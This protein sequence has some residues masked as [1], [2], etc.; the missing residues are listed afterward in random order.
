MTLWTWKSLQIDRDAGDLLDGQEDGVDRAVA[1][2]RCAVCSSSPR[3]RRER[4]FRH[5]AGA[6]NHAIR[7]ERPLL[8]NGADLLLDQGRDVGVVDF[9]LLVGQDLELLEDRVELLAA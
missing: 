9:F 5:L 1:A 2:R 8:G 7:I 3:R 6:A 4:H